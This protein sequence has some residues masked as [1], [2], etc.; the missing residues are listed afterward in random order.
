MASPS[1]ISDVSDNLLGQR[2]S[3]VQEP[4]EDAEDDTSTGTWDR[5][6]NFIDQTLWGDFNHYN[7]VVD[8]V[9]ECVPFTLLQIF[10]SIS[11]FI[12]MVLTAGYL[13]IFVKKAIEHY[14]FWQLVFTTSAFAMLFV[15]SGR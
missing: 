10:R 5:I 8:T 12:M 9:F 4:L 7:T 15:G 13:Y 11:L 14:N 1:D 2:P 3:K 6:K